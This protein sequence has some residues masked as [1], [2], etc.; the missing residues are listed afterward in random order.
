ML[1]LQFVYEYSYIL[2][3][4]TLLFQGD[5][6]FDHRGLVSC[7][8]SS[9][10]P[11]TALVH[12]VIKAVSAPDAFLNLTYQNLPKQGRHKRGG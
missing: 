7:S 1:V 9:S 5:G 6:V 8:S 11:M 3:G 2:D 10:S 12:L 4:R